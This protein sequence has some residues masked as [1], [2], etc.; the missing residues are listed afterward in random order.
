VYCVNA[1]NAVLDLQNRREY[2]N[3]W[4][5]ENRE[6]LNRY[7]KKYRKNKR[8]YQKSWGEPITRLKR[9]TPNNL[10]LIDVN[11]FD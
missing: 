2:Q 6:K 10:L 5:K 8:A 4:H 11:L 9:D 3:K 7:T 1:I